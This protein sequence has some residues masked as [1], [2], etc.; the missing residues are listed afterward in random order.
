MRVRD[1]VY[2]D[3]EIKSMWNAADKFD[4]PAKGAYFKL[5]VLLGPRKS[6]LAGMKWSDIKDDVWT[7]P[8]EHTKSR[9]TAKPRTYTTPLPPLAAR[10]LSGLSRAGDDVFGN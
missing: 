3:A 8:F 4:D 1:R 6:A 5:L 2:S 10:I 9:K 7:T